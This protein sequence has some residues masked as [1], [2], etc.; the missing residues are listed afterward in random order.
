VV[1]GIIHALMLIKTKE[2]AR[3]HIF[4]FEYRLIFTIIRREKLLDLYE[5]TL[6]LN[7][8]RH[9]TGI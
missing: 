8:D 5:T 4:I 1:G 6:I 2:N 7:R 3:R 9:A